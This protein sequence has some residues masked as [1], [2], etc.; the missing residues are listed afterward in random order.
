MDCICCSIGANETIGEYL[1]GTQTQV[2][3]MSDEVKKVKQKR[4]KQT[5]AKG[6]KL[7]D[8]RQLTIRITKLNPSICGYLPLLN[9][10]IRSTRII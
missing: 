6:T 1:E 4:M 7:Y 2:V 3:S 10:G 9:G 8:Q 5:K